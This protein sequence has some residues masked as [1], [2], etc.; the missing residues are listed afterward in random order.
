MSIR[1]IYRWTTSAQWQSRLKRFYGDRYLSS[2]DEVNKIL[3]H[4]PVYYLGWGKYPPLENAKAMAQSAGMDGLSRLLDKVSGMDH[5]AESW[6]WHSAQYHFE[7]KGHSGQYRYYLV[8]STDDQQKIANVVT[9]NLSQ[10]RLFGHLR[11]FFPV[12]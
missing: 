2:S 7:P 12:H 9:C 10:T 4:G 6:M 1:Q 5:L 11:C 8:T 3:E